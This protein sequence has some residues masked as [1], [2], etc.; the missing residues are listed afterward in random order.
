LARHHSRSSLSLTFDCPQ[1]ARVHYNDT[2]K[3]LAVGVGNLNV[4]AFYGYCPS[5][6]AI[7]KTI[8]TPQTYQANGLGAFQST[9]QPR[10]PRGSNEVEYPTEGS[11]VLAGFAEECTGISGYLTLCLNVAISAPGDVYVALHSIENRRGRAFISLGSDET[12]ANETGLASEVDRGAWFSATS[13][14]KLGK[15]CEA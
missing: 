4:T 1:E 15:K 8:V 10:T 14:I 12:R 11:E 7:G 13:E 9:F 3:P 6:W 2:A 5:L